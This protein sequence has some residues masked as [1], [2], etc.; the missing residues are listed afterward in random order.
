ENPALAL[1]EG[2]AERQARLVAQWM[3]LGF[4]HGVMNTDNMSLSGE[5]IDYGPCAF[6]DRYDPAKKFSFIDRGGRYAYGNQPNIAHWNLARLAEALLPLIHEDEPEAVR[7]ATSVLE[8][9]PD[10]FSEAWAKVFAAKTGFARADEPARTL[11]ERLL[12]SMAEQGIDFTLAFRHLRA[13][14]EEGGGEAFLKLF[15]RPEPVREWLDAW[16]GRLREAGIATDEA[17]VTMRAANPVY[18]PRN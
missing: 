10:R 7:L 17:A 5:T 18:I 3:G 12:A 1:L 9:F 8:R 15:P 16:R 11:A 14:A 2:V 13:A 4:I 6:L